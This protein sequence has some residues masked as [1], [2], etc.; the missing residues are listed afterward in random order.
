[1]SE[2]RSPLTGR[3]FKKLSDT[4]ADAKK[5]GDTTPNLYLEGDLYESLQFEREPGTNNLIIGVDSSE[6]GKADGHNNFSGDSPLPQRRFLADSESGEQFKNQNKILKDTLPLYE[7][8]VQAAIE[9]YF[10]AL[11][12]ATSSM[13]FEKAIET[14]NQQA[15]ELQRPSI[16]ESE[17]NKITFKQKFTKRGKTAVTLGG[18]TIKDL[19]GLL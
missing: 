2:G 1:M 17:I 13:P 9:D 5:N 19:K 6:E 14:I 3:N 4:Y 12:K 10:V 18:I 11:E 15:Q 7:E 16:S 8:D